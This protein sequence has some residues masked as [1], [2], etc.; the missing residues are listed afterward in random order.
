MSKQSFFKLSELERESFANQDQYYNYNKKTVGQEDAEGEDFCF[1]NDDKNSNFDYQSDFGESSGD[2]F[3]N[4]PADLRNVNKDPERQRTRTF[5]DDIKI[6][7]GMIKLN[8]TDWEQGG[9]GLKKYTLY[10]I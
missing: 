9:S 3:D 4:K 8:I 2:L 6:N 7:D 1:A 10:H 5:T